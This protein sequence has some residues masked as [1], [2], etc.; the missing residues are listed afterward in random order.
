[1]AGNFYVREFER[2]ARDSRGETVMVGEEPALADQK[3]AFADTGVS[4]TLDDRT[5]FVELHTDGIC[6]YRISAASVSTSN[7]R[8]GADATN[9]KGVANGAG[10][11]IWVVEG[12]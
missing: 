6:H 12:V 7:M 11:Q 9:F 4:L 8:L 3:L 2:L 10:R 5:R 1:M